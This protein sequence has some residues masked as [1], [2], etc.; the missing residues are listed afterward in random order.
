MEAI[1]HQDLRWPSQDGEDRSEHFALILS[2][3]FI[4]QPK[5]GDEAFWRDAFSEIERLNSELREQF[6]RAAIEAFDEVLPDR[7][8]PNLQST[9]IIEVATTDDNE[10]F[11]IRSI[12]QA[13]S[14]SV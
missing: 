10:I 1:D 6:T 2:L 14:S 9:D 12:R 4:E 7:S 11:P 5:P 13:D 3:A 8:I